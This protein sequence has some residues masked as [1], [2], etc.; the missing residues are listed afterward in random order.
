MTL[1]GI[2]VGTTNCKAGLFG[3]DGSM[4]Q[5]ASRPTVSHRNEQ[6]HFSYNPEELWQTIASA[7]REITANGGA[8]EI[9]AIGIASQAESGLLLDVATG[10]ARCAFIPWYDNR[11]MQETEEIRAVSDPLERFSH[12]GLH[13]SF[14][15]GLSKLLWLRKR[16]PDVLKGAIWLSAADYIAYR[17]T[18]KCGTDNTLAARTYGFRID[19]K[20]WDTEWLHRFNLNETLFPEVL[21]SGHPVGTL[22]ADGLSGLGLPQGISV[23]VSG[24]DHVCA[25]LATHAVEPGK[26]YDSMGTAETLVGTLY[27]REL[28]QEEFD[29]GLSY[30]R[31]VVKDR[32]FWM[33]GISASG[34]SV[35]WLRSQLGDPPLSYE[36][37]GSII[38]QLAD[39]PTGILY[40]PYLSGSGAPIPDPNASG[41]FVGLR[42]AHTR[43]HM[44]KA[45]LEGTA[46]QMEAIRRSAETITRQPIK[47]VLAV[48]GGTRNHQWMQIKADVAGCAFDI[49]DLSEATL[50]G[51]ALAAGIGCGFYGNEQEALRAVT[52]RTIATMMPD[53]KRHDGYRRLFEHGYQMLQAPLRAYYNSAIQ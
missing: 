28:G 37:M 33:G 53:P 13:L 5:L 10:K 50:L 14:K 48:G 6:G 34:G 41:A 39:E 35:E 12:T 9:A 21:P 23:A 32:L 46:Y 52:Y 38:E 4:I 49:A 27:E 44:I 31:H 2:D 47:R 18:G 51:A 26:V 15:Y 8:R 16:D 24:H 11:S 43:G 36:Q 20:T 25:S 40:F 45:V 30:G 1:L 7:I 42:K 3:A 19:R 17:L 22:A 29:S